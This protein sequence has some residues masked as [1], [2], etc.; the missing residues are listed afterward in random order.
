MLHFLQDNYG[1]FTSET[2]ARRSSFRIFIGRVEGRGWFERF[3]D[4]VETSG[5]YDASASGTALSV[6]P[7]RRTCPSAARLEELSARFTGA[8]R[9]T[10]RD[11][12]QEIWLGHDSDR[13]VRVGGMVYDANS[14][15]SIE[16]DAQRIKEAKMP[17]F[18]AAMTEEAKALFGRIISGEDTQQYDE[19]SF[20]RE[21]L[22]RAVQRIHLSEDDIE[23]ITIERTVRLLSI[24]KHIQEAVT[25]YRITYEFVERV[26]EGP[27]QTVPESRVTQSELDFEQLLWSWSFGKSAAIIEGLLSGL[28]YRNNR[29]R[30]DAGVI[31]L[32]VEAA[33]GT[34][35]VLV[36]ITI[37]EL[38]YIGR[39][40]FGNARWSIR[41]F[42][43]T[44][45]DGYLMAL[46]FRGAGI[47]GRGIAGRIGT[48][49]IRQL[50][51]GWILERITVGVIGGAGSA[52]LT[53]FCHDII[54]VVSGQGG[55]SSLRTYITHM[56]WGAALGTVFEFGVGALQP[57]LR[58]GGE[59]GLETLAQVVTRVRESGISPARWTALSA[60]ALSNL[61][62]RFGEILTAARTGELARWFGERLNQVTERLGETYRLAVFRRILELSPESLTRQS[63]EGLEKFLSLSRRDLTNEAALNILN[64][65]NA[66]ELHGFL[67]ALNTRQSA[68]S[69]CRGRSW[70]P[71]PGHPR[72]S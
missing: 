13:R 2:R 6:N 12:E 35:A 1:A 60:E 68:I 61:Q 22:G 17:E 63:V 48:A 57:I 18:R 23:E 50:I 59:T 41:E 27:W 20:T 5:R 67:E 46:A 64:R 25:R 26:N 43:T 40:I 56:A 30:L 14:V 62:Q 31:A 38:I 42:L 55:W 16:R 72:R 66:A 4:Q 21:V 28:Y 65:L 32:L 19:E 15:Y 34:T 51:G 9:H 36:S 33:G 8:L 37:A 11:R 7:L 39:V 49:S 54:R 10:Y 53:T 71:C 24:E 52:A 3:Y 69:A 45:L 44:A 29:H 58:A 70:K 47:F